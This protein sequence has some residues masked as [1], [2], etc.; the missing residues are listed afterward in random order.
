LNHSTFISQ[1]LSTSV[2]S[3]SFSLKRRP[4]QHCVSMLQTDMSLMKVTISDLRIVYFAYEKFGVLFNSPRPWPPGKVTGLPA[5][6]RRDFTSAIGIRKAG[7]VSTLYIVS[8]WD[9]KMGECLFLWEGRCEDCVC[10][11]MTLK[12]NTQCA[13]R[14][15]TSVIERWVQF[16]SDYSVEDDASPIFLFRQ[17]VFR[18]ALEQGYC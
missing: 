16:D 12:C 4:L 17:V 1:N 13:S 15:V 6:V 7:Q 8:L 18:S 3:S 5:R 11:S 2:F 10:A 9:E 14:L